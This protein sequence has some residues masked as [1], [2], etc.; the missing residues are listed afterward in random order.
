VRRALVL[1]LPCA[2]HVVV[3]RERVAL[4]HAGVLL[5]GGHVRLQLGQPVV[6]ELVCAREVRVCDGVGALQVWVE[7]RDDAAV[8]VGGEVEGLR[9][10]LGRLERLDGVVDDGVRLQMLI[11][12]VSRTVFEVWGDWVE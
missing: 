8:R 7:R 10:D 2:S 6:A 12:W 9:A 1:L 11:G 5:D 4:E 3:R